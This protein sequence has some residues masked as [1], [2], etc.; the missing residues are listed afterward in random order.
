LFHVTGKDDV[1]QY[2]FTCEE[3]WSIKRVTNEVPNIAKMDT[4]FRDWAIMW[5]MK[6]NATFSVG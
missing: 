1:E 3:I 2:W 6:Y 4:M 5:Y